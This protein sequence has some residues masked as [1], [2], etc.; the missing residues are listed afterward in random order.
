MRTTTESNAVKKNVFLPFIIKGVLVA[1]FIML[2]F[3]SSP[4]P[5]AT[6]EPQDTGSEPGG[7]GAYELPAV[8]VTAQKREEDVQRIPMS[9]SVVG[10]TEIQD[11][12]IQNTRELSRYVPNIYVRDAGNYHQTTIRGV[13]GFVNSLH[14]AVGLYVDDVNLPIVY[15]QNPELFD[16]ERVE[17]LKGPQ[18]TLYGRNS[19]SGV[20]NIVT[21]QPD[22]NFRGKVFAEYNA[23]DTS[24]GLANGGK[25]G[26]SL[27][28]P[29]KEDTLFIG[30]S[31]KWSYTEGYVKNMFRSDR[32]ATDYNDVD[33]RT[34]LRWTPDDRWEIR[35]TLDASYGDDGMGYGRFLK[36]PD[37]T[38]NGR[39]NWDEDSRRIRRSDGQSLRIKYSGDSVDVTS[40]TGRRYFKDDWNIDMDLT[41]ISSIASDFKEDNSL[42]SQE[43]RLSS[44]PDSGPLQWLTGVY[45]YKEDT[46]V[47][48][49]YDYVAYGYSDRRY[50]DINIKGAAVFAQ[51]TYT[52][53]DRLH[54]TAGGRYDYIDLEA[55]QNYKGM[56]TDSSYSAGRNDGEFLPKFSIGFDI[57]DNFMTYATVAKGYLAG[58]FDYNSPTS[59]DT[60]SYAPEYTWN[61]ELGAKSS[62]FDNKLTLNLAA[63]YI[64]MKDK[65]VSEVDPAT[66]KAYISN[67][68]KAHSYGFEL[69]M[70]ARPYQGWEVFGG[71]GYTKTKVDS[72]DGVGM[73]GFYDH[74]GNELTYAP[75]Y[76]Y[77]LGVQYMHETG[78]FGRLELLGTGPFYHDVE[79]K[80]REKSYELVN[81]RL[82]YENDNFEIAF[83]CKNIFNTQYKNVRFDWGNG[84]IA[85]FDGEPRQFG[86]TIAFKF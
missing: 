19:E 65:Q 17:V 18:C 5:G 24:H 14:S 21:R 26:L 79:N 6:A 25:G 23:Y 32:H 71:Y 78:V 61:Y 82:G 8:V 48:S 56:F 31:G 74:A 73:K 76:T 60:L 53:F 11:A 52:L 20:I 62:W 70:Q 40:I 22:N 43:F 10:N 37:G 75:Q 34:V 4:V 7:A 45:A 27:S 80:L 2:L 69:E 51:A 46:K 9:V 42:L 33:G 83:W 85:G 35:F 50:T 39:I 86:T 13:S 59:S 1:L 54:L 72:W 49:F 63:F 64:D 28:G 16:V 15:M 57:T 47:T 12:G 58:G 30:F 44:S 29:I 3:F 84:M 67:A 81:A 68:G 77:N 41:P 38:G 36:G 55:K 66:Y